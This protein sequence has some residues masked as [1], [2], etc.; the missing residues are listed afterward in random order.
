MV[1][2]HILYLNG[3]F[4]HFMLLRSIPDKLAGVVALALPLLLYFLFLYTQTTS[5]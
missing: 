5:T 3:I 1:L 2:L 4:Y